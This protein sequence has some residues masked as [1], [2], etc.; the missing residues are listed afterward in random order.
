MVLFTTEGCSYCERFI[1]TSLG[2][3]QLA[4]ALQNDFA[5]VG[6]EI[7]SD[8]EMTSPGG[9]VMPVKAF[10]KQQGVGFSPTLL[11]FGTD[12]ERV[13]RLVGYQSPERFA[14]ILS[15][16]GEGNYRNVTLADY[17]SKISD[18]DRSGKGN[19]ELRPDPLFSSPPYALQRNRFAAERPLLVLFEKTGCTECDAFHDTVLAERGVRDLLQ[20][21]EVVR[22]D[23]SDRNTPLITPK[24]QRT[25]PAE[26]YGETAFSRVPALLFF[27]EKGNNALQTDALVLRQRMM[28]S[29]YYMLERAYEKGWSYQ[30][31]ARTRAIEKSNNQ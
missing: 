28:N 12:G 1:R 16:L 20:Q 2:N 25:T 5:S 19:A 3:E 24:G 14:M 18:N 11:F 27:D 10:A 9:A 22:L 21:F 30:R 31:Y 17:I 8:Q 15:Y 7:F 29:L 4:T 23:A 13:L 6:L 26:W